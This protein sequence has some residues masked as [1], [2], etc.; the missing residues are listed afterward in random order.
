[1]MDS[2]H[3]KRTLRQSTGRLCMRGKLV[4]GK[5]TSQAVAISVP[6]EQ[7]EQDP[8]ECST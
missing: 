5:D 3:E 7:E 8:H 6:L 2:G 1:M 4:S